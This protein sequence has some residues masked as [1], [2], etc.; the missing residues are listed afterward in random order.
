MI[1]IV[2]RPLALGTRP[3]QLAR[4]QTGYVAGLLQAAAPGLQVHQVV[5]STEGDR[6]LDKPLPEIG[7][8]GLFTTELEI[9]LHNGE[10]DLV[11]HSL[12]DL[13][14]EPVDGLVVAAIPP[15][16]DARDVLISPGG[17]TLDSLPRGARVGTSSLR[18]AAQLLA[19]RPDLTLLPL[20]GNVDTRIRKAEQ[21]DYDAIVLAAAG[22]TRL[23]LE[24]K[25]SEYLT[26]EQMLPAP[27][28]G[29]LAVQCRFGDDELLT[30][31][32]QIDDL[33]ARAAVEAERAFLLG[34]GGGCSAPVA[35]YA[36]HSLGQVSLSG[37]AA[38]ADGRNV[39]RVQGVGPE[40]RALGLALA[41]NAL[42]Q[43][44][45]AWL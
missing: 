38:S 25:I 2:S 23:G 14:V 20:R 28:Q 33:A 18:R 39:V 45:G 10:I 30:L 22:V 9:A 16:A 31:L 21:G 19:H 17:W 15:R 26:F 8:K 32:T 7:G 43:G 6:V 41:K 35:A 5:I 27:G 44:A 24:K 29:A 12:K 13:P 1:P 42:E 40:G 37:L 34:L 36:T 4:W 3:S 11:V